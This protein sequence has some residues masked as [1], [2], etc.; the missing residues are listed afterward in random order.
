[1]KSADRSLNLIPEYICHYIQEF[2]WKDASCPREPDM[3]SRKDLVGAPRNPSETDRILYPPLPVP[4]LHE[5]YENFW[6]T[7]S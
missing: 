2:A 7:G 4:Y 3:T 1:M 5:P 6:T